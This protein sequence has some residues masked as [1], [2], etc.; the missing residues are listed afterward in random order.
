[1]R[2]AAFRF[3]TC[4]LMSAFAPVEA[5]AQTFLEQNGEVVIEVEAEPATGSW[6]VLTNIPGYTGTSFYRWDGAQLSQGGTGLLTYQIQ[7]QN[8]GNYQFMFR[9]RITIGTDDKE[10]NDTFVS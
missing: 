10:H 1:M 7:I 2:T 4:A 3:V 6:Q 9:S 8:P 5:L